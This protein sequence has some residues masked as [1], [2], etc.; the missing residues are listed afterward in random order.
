MT[1]KLS[2]V[3]PC[4]NEEKT[5]PLFYA[6][7]QDVKP[8]LRGAE[9]EYWFINDGSEDGTLDILRDLQQKDPQ[10]VH[11]ISFSRNFGK[12]AA[13]YAGL[14][15]T[16]GDYVAVMDADLQDPPEQLAEMLAGIEDEGYDV[17]GTRRIDRGGE[18]MIRSFFANGFYWFINKISSTPI[19]NGVR[20]FRLMTRQ[21]V[22]AVLSMSEYNR[23][24]KGILSWVGFKTKYLSYE[25]RDRVGG[26]TSWSFWKLLRYSIDGIID[27]SDA[28][29][30]LATL[31]GFL[32]FLVSLMGVV[33][34]IVRKIIYGGSVTGW[35]SM[36]SIILMIGGLQLLCLGILG[37]Y[38]GSIYL[39]AKKRPI[40]II[41]EKK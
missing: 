19:K 11:Y 37:K 4:F 40:Y 24:S 7:L 18:P 10:Q 35:A 38:I 5:V 39:E 16:T 34:V 1:K 8:T 33:F 27:F 15:A 6:A 13:L 30:N 9:L 41:K 2:L 14:Q 22:D 26:K 3:V 32:S 12:E 17:V 20:D 28:P 25:N 36:V 31:V 29:L 23:F 21:V